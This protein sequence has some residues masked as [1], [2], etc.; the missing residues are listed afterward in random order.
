MALPNTERILTDEMIAAIKAFFP[1]YP[2]KQAVTLPAL[3]IVNERLRYVPLA[4]G[5]R[6]RRA[7]GAGAGRGAGH[8]VVLRLLQAGRA[9]RPHAGLGLPLDQ[10]RLRGGEEVLDHLCHKLGIQPGRDDARRP[11]TLEFAECLGACEFAPCMLADDDA[12]QGPDATR[13]PTQFLKQVQRN[14]ISLQFAIDV[15][16]FDARVRTSPARQHRQARQP[17]AARVRGDRRLSGAAEGAQGDD[18]GGGDR[19]GQGQQPA[20]PR[21]GRLSR[22]G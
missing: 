5:G 11:L 4:G 6:D 20:R 13:R 7:A 18:A 21:R 3:H 16:T 2:T 22:R 1:R 12:A 9:A 17:H 19:D 15:T 14:A 8:A 10:L